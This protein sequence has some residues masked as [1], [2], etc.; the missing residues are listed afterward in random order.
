[1]P[2]YTARIV[3]FKKS[4]RK[5]GHYYPVF[6]YED[7]SGNVSQYI[8]KR[9]V[10]RTPFDNNKIYTICKNKF[11]LYEKNEKKLAPKMYFI[12]LRFVLLIIT[13]IVPKF[14]WWAV[15]ISVLTLLIYQF[16]KGIK[17]YQLSSKKDEMECVDGKIIGYKK[18]RK[19]YLLYYPEIKYLPLIEYKYGEKSYIRISKALCANDQ[20][21]PNAIC[22]IYIDA[23][24]Q[25][26]VDEFDINAPL[27]KT[28]NAITRSVDNTC[29]A[30][31]KRAL[32]L[33]LPFV[34]IHRRRL[35]IDNGPE[36]TG[37]L[38]LRTYEYQK[39]SNW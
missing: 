6:E 5:P 24:A 38:P 16:M 13:L 25:L 22:K 1:M 36:L 28:K 37:P 33:E 34:T 35:V 26:V 17:Q 3:D 18:V 15:A 39:A 2:R 31:I 4:K 32:A 20:Q 29:D 21:T 19:T 23:D 14:A 11:G 10:E 9:Y 8:R 30:I 12:A 7:E 27:I